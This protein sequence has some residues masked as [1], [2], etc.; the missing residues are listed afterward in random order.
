MIIQFN[1]K[2]DKVKDLLIEF[3]R[4]HP[5][6][7]AVVATDDELAVGALKFALQSGIEIPEKWKWLDAIIQCCLF[8]VIPNCLRLIICAKHCV[9][10]WLLH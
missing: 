7:D 1:E 6:I 3:Y 4:E 10:Q 2:I 5:Q 8:L 9:S